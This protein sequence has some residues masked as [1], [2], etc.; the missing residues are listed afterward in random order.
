[1]V[2]A[3]SGGGGEIEQFVGIVQQLVVA[4][5][6][7]HHEDYVGIVVERVDG[8]VDRGVAVG[9][10]H[11]HI[12]LQVNEFRFDGLHHRVLDFGEEGRLY[13]AVEGHGSQLGLG[14][15]LDGVVGALA[16]VEHHVVVIAEELVGHAHDVGLG[17][18]L[19][20]GETLHGVSPVFA[21]DE[22]VDE[23]VSAR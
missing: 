5:A 10:E 18:A 2:G 1:M 23:V 20:G 9:A 19:E 4:I 22:C 11:G 8:V 17:H 16:L 7:F 3:H 13:V 6:V 12:L 14:H 21:V 15:L